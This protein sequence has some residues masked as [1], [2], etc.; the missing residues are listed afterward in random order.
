[1]KTKLFPCATALA[2]A[3]ALQQLSIPARADSVSIQV[4][5]DQLIPY[6]EWVS[7][8]DYGYVWHPR[9]IDAEWRPYTVGSWAYTD[10]GWTWISDEPFGW[11]TYHYGRWAELEN[12]GWAWVPDTEWAPAWVAWRSNDQYVGWAPLPPEARFETGIGFHSWVDSYYEIG[13]T[14]YSFVRL[15]DFG[16]PRLRA[17]VVPPRENLVIVNETR[18]I[19]NITSVNRIVVNQGPE[20]DVLARSSAQPIRKLRLERET[21]IARNVSPDDLRSEVH[22][23]TLRVLAPGITADRALAPKEVQKKLDRVAVDRGWRNAGDTRQ[24][25][26]L[27][28]RITREAPKDDKLPTKQVRRATTPDRDQPQAEDNTR[29]KEKPA[30]VAESPIPGF[31]RRQAQPPPAPDPTQRRMRDRS[32]EIDEDAARR[33]APNPQVPGARPPA[34]P[35]QPAQETVPEPA[36]RVRS[37]LVQVTRKPRSTSHQ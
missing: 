18:N 12:L 6:G 9:D 19:T 36:P 24:V 5:Y 4:F 35:R 1:M 27:R 32:V 34:P 23:D 25:E 15:P 30:P 33:Q 26:E 8:A 29:R 20:F 17:V 31:P 7:T 11:A 2:A 21:K 37:S 13:P 10:A 16:A 14:H 22:G 3:F 28:A